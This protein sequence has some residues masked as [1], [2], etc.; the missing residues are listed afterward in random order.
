VSKFVTL[1]KS[2]GVVSIAAILD[3]IGANKYTTEFE[4]A[5][6]NFGPNDDQIAM[7]LADSASNTDADTALAAAAL[8][9]VSSSLLDITVDVGTWI[10]ADL[11]SIVAYPSDTKFAKVAIAIDDA[12]GNPEVYVFEKTTGAYGSLPGGKTFCV[13]LKEYSVPAA[14]TVLTELNDWIN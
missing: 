2:A 9:V 3:R 1:V 10:V 5:Q 11:T 12:T 6:T 14:G 7:K 13:D 8:P 4:G